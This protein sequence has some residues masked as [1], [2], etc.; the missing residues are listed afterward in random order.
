MIYPHPVLPEFE[1]IRLKTAEEAVNFLRNHPHQSHPFLGGTDCFVAVRDRKIKPEYLVDLKPLSG[2][3]DLSFDRQRGLTIGA[4]V[5][6]NRL[7]A[8]PDVQTLYPL[9]AAAAREV[10]SY[11][12]RTRA[13]LVGNLC[14]ASPCGDTIAPCMVYQGTAH[15]LGSTTPKD[16]PLV[17]FF[18]GPGETILDCGE[19]VQSVHLPLP[20]SG[21]RG[22]YLSI[23]RN[24]LG[25]LAIAAVTVL[26][27]TGSSAASRYQFRIALSA[28]GP[29]VIFVEQAQRLLAEGPID[30]RALENAAD[31]ASQSCKPIDDIRSSAR[32]RRE[33]VRTLTHRALQKVW[34]DLQGKS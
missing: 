1:Y 4:A 31:I 26:G 9:I 30:E 15:I 16:V 24:A 18:K 2:F 32:Y 10:G 21:A 19:I 33:M 22:A 14:N 28:V 11:S 20:P 13:T 27:F 6:L 17:D 7:I 29:T 5:S 34:A 8:S 23:G 25:D 3:N 12:L